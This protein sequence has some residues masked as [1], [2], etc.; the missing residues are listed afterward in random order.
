M[1]KSIIIGSIA[2]I[3]YYL[4]FLFLYIQNVIN[5][6]TFVFI[7]FISLLIPMLLVFVFWKKRV[8]KSTFVTVTFILFLL[9]CYELPLIGFTKPPSHIVFA[10]SEPIEALEGTNIYSVRVNKITLDNVKSNQAAKE[11]LTAQKMDVMTVSE[12]NR[13]I[14]YESKNEQL[15]KWL[16]LQKD[17]SP[18]E[19]KENVS[20]YLG[21]EEKWLTTFLNQDNI[22]GDSAGLSLAIIGRFKQDDFQNHLPIAVTG[23]IKENGDV[24]GVGNL[25][26]KI[27]I[28]EKAGIPFLIVPSE[29]SAE[30][31]NLQ[32]ELQANVEIYNVSTV[33]E[34]VTLIRTLN[35]KR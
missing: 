17:H 6:F 13:K 14:V 35:E 34:A 22:G 19:T 4:A 23:A 3:L 32:K 15:A 26:E 30:V 18:E 11:F 25:K 16:H 24:F 9:F 33:D 7:L 5:E 29:D 8:L 12:V 20:K 27:Q 21:R 31:S 10:Y 28:T 2:S 1:I